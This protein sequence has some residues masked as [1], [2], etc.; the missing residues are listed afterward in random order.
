MNFGRKKIT[1]FII[2]AVVVLGVLSAYSISIESAAANET[3]NNENVSS[4]KATLTP[5]K[6]SY[7]EKLEP[8]KNFGKEN[9]LWVVDYPDNLTS[10]SLLKFDLSTIPLGA[11][12][13]NATLN[14]YLYNFDDEDNYE[15]SV[16]SLNGSWTE[17]GVTWNNAPSYTTSPID[18]IPVGFPKPP[19]YVSWDV[20]DAVKSMLETNHGFLVKMTNENKGSPRKMKMFRSRENDSCSPEL[21]VEYSEWVPYVPDNEEVEIDISPP[22]PTEDNEITSE[23]TI[24]FSDMGY[25][26]KDWGDVSQNNNVFSVNA[27]IEKDTG[28]SPQAIKTVENSYSLGYLEE[29]DY[30][31]QFMAW[32]NIVKTEEFTVKGAAFEQE[33]TIKVEGEGTTDPPLGTHTYEEGEEVTINAVPD[34]N[35]EF[36]EWS[37]DVSS[38][39]KEITVTMDENKVITA[40]FEEEPVIP[41]DESQEGLPWLW[42]GAGVT[43]AI[44]I[45]IILRFV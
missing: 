11:E 35:W 33:L 27:E 14:L 17:T 43:V 29:G 36:V 15:V 32:D 21:V 25:R 31:F 34:N 1:T 42:I 8:S 45:I 28:P 9:T 44:L 38:E 41:P 24:T 12:I 30:E 23:V 39:E 10:R 7:I 19:H 4:Q 22:S 37:G 20:T 40:N 18:T 2:V 3:S 13:D 26:V 6:D 16:H 5:T